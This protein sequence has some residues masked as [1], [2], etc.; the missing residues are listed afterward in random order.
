[1]WKDPI[2]DEVR[3]VRKQLEK[4]YGSTMDSIFKRIC[5][6][7]KQSKAR[8]VKFSPKPRVLKKAA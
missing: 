5:E 6:Q 4:E 2:V 8:L 7:Q 3:K 1:M